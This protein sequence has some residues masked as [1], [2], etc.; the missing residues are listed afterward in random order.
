VEKEEEEVV[1]E[2]W[3]RYKGSRGVGYEGGGALSE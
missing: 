1:V 3:A 2:D